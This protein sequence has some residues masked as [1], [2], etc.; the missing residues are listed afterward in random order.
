[1]LQPE[2]IAHCEMMMIEMPERAIVE[3]LLIK[4]R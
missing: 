3:E 1:M 4:P 2:D